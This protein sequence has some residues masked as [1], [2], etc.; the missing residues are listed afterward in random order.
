MISLQGLAG[1]R[2][3]RA[4]QQS[5]EYFDRKYVKKSILYMFVVR[6][7]V[8]L[9]IKNCLKDIKNVGYVFLVHVQWCM[10]GWG[11]YTI[12]NM[13]VTVKLKST[14]GCSQSF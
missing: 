7:L 14:Y 10:S 2:N 6:D 1:S 9:N 8:L 12:Y 5:K 3:S 13:S 4:V 11:S